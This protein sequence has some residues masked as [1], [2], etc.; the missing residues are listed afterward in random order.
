MVNRENLIFKTNKYICQFKQFETIKSSAKNI[1][2]DKIILN[3]ANKDRS[4]LLTEI[5]E[6]KKNTKTVDKLFLM[7][8]KVEYFHYNQL[9]A[10][11]ALLTYLSFRRC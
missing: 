5:V 9:K 2:G 10:H 6:F 7:L 8:L 3:N 11:D 4:N 1:F